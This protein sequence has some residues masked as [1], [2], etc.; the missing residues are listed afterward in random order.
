MHFRIA[1][2]TVH[3]QKLRLS[4]ARLRRDHNSKSPI[5][6]PLAIA[7]VFRISSRQTDVR[8]NNAQISLSLAPRGA[9][10]HHFSPAWKT[11][12]SFA[13]ITPKICKPW[14]FNNCRKRN[15]LSR[16]WLK[17]FCL[18]GLEFALGI[19]PVSSCGGCCCQ[20]APPPISSYRPFLA[21]SQSR[22]KH[23]SY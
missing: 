6:S 13:L 17:H 5:N 20:K 4:I 18:R 15:S 11:F 1:T 8:S 21:H 14:L 12:S 2:F 9:I 16:P 10:F 23:P 22:S 19:P 3:S 7:P